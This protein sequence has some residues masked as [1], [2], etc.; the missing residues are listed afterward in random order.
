MLNDE[1]ATKLRW[2]IVHLSDTCEMTCDKKAHNN[3][4]GCWDGLLAA[5]DT[6]VECRNSH[7]IRGCFERTGK[8]TEMSDMPIARGVG[9][10]TE[11]SSLSATK[12][13]R[14]NT[15]TTTAVTPPR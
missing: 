2:R 6:L 5:E 13:T 7:E 10:R 9:I 15:K 8:R 14:V 1:C 11:V 3:R 12:A 4:K